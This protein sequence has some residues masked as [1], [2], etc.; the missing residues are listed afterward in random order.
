LQPLPGSLHK[1]ALQIWMSGGIGGQGA[2]AHLNLKGHHTHKNGEFFTDTF[3]GHK[4][5][6]LHLVKRGILCIPLNV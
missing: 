4:R 2:A 6:I 3:Q 5:F 1:A